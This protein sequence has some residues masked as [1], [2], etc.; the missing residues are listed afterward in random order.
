M[1]LSLRI[2]SLITLIA[3]AFTAQAAQAEPENPIVQGSLEVQVIG[4]GKVT[5]TGIDC[6]SDCSQG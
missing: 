3:F 1:K 5:G 4:G 6:G 2:A